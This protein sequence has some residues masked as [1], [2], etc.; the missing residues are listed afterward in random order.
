VVDHWRKK[1]FAAIKNLGISP[2]DRWWEQLI[3]KCKI[4]IFGVRFTEQSNP[5]FELFGGIRKM[6]EVKGWICRYV[7]KPWKHHIVSTKLFSQFLYFLVYGRNLWLSSLYEVWMVVRR[8][9]IAVNV[10]F[11]LVSNRAEMHFSMCCSAPGGKLSGKGTIYMST[12]RI[13]FV[14]SH[15]VG[16]IFAFDIPLVQYSSWHNSKY[17]IGNK[18]LLML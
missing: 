17:S 4:G 16:E 5:C 3:C 11:K 10:L 18:E 8:R 12:F 15:S 1:V 14:L 9:R 13:V 7:G 2:V 6:M